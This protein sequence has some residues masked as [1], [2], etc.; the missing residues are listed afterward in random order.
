[1]LAGPAHSSVLVLSYNEIFTSGIIC[2]SFQ[3]PGRLKVRL[4][5]AR[6]LPVMDRASDLTDAFVEVV[7]VISSFPPSPFLLLCLTSQPHLRLSALLL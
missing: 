4:L 1:M 6:D 3:M 2:V 7:T 5:A